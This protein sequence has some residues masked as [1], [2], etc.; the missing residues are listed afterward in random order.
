MGV[1]KK[2]AFFFVLS[3]LVFSCA[4]RSNPFKEIDNAVNLNDFERGIDAIRKGQEGINKLYPERNA[5]SLFLDKGLLEH[6]AGNFF[7]SSKDLEEA[8]R[9]IEEAF[10]RSITAEIAS[11]IINDKIREYPGEDYEDIYINIINA[12][13]YYQANN[14]EEAMVEIRKITISSGKLDML[15]RK[16]ATSSK[17]AGDWV[18]EQLKSLGLQ[19]DPALPQGTPVNFSN[20]ALARYLS[21]LFYDS[22][23]DADNARLEA[24]HLKAAFADNKK[25]Y[26]FPIPKAASEIQNIPEGMARL[27][28]IGFSGLSP[29]KEEKLYPGF[30]PFF[31][32]DPLRRIQFR[33]PVFVDRKSKN[34]IDRIEVTVNNPERAGAGRRFNLELIEN[35]GE[36]MRETYNARFSNL[37]LKTYIRTMTKYAA[38]DIAATKI[39]KESDSSLAAF[40]S[41]LAAKVTIDAS[42]GADTRMSRYFPDKAYIGGINLRPGTYTVTATYY[43]GPIVIAEDNARDINVLV[44][45]LNLIETFCL[46]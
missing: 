30:F 41:A 24:E 31:I 4:S 19:I 33:L 16:Y 18:V 42:E 12:L 8:E 36:V 13:N 32:N 5:I 20:S 46:R 34:P 6:Y 10:T 2:T 38:A 35:L 22:L 3:L 26:N 25:I 45:K 9:L 39:G 29:I 15:S 1:F 40:G 43:S 21:V 27:N 28:V 11:Y 44:N 17:S 23:G 7:E 37:Y 14:I